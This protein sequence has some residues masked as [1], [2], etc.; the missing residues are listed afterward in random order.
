MGAQGTAELDFGSTPLREGSVV[1]TGQA[2]ILAGSHAEAFIMS[3]ASADNSAD[4]H[5]QLNDN[6]TLIVSDIVA[7]TGF[8][9][10][11]AL[12]SGLASQRF[13]IRWVWN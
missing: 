8:T 10:K 5:E 4:A 9:I 1:I 12:L 2:G 11:C 13:N 6:C 3:E 7:G